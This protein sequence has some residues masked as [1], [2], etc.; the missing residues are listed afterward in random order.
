M[1]V[2]DLKTYDRTIFISSI[3]GIV[4]SKIL[5]IEIHSV[6]DEINLTLT[7]HACFTFWN[8]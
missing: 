1:L 8:G 5:T 2:N 7:N 3:V 6:F 4:S